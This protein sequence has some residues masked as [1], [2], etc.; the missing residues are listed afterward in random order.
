MVQF[1]SD[2][3]GAQVYVDEELRGATPLELRLMSEK[4]YVIIFRM[5][6][7]TDQVQHLVHHMDMTWYTVNSLTF[8]VSPLWIPIDWFTGALHDLRPA[9]VHA[10]FR[11]SEPPPEP[12]R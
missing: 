10:S 7:H 8:P 12:A 2:P 3:A 5:P 11:R 1:T 6:G 9:I 4:D